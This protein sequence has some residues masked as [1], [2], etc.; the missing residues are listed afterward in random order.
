MSTTTTLQDLK[1]ASA[2]HLPGATG[3]GFVNVI[4][5]DGTRNTVNIF[6]QTAEDADTL[7]RAAI[8][9]KDLLTAAQAAPETG[10]E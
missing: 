1:T 7:I 4:L 10:G 8:A 6:I 3:T 9:A 2:E 5:G